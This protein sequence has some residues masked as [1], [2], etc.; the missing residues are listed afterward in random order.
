MDQDTKPGNLMEI[1]ALFCFIFFL[2]ECCISDSFS[3]EAFFL[4]PV[5]DEVPDSAMLTGAEAQFW[6]LLHSGGFEGQVFRWDELSGEAFSSKTQPLSHAV[7]T[8]RALPPWHSSLMRSHAHGLLLAL[9]FL[10]KFHHLPS[11]SV[12]CFF[13]G[14]TQN[15]RLCPCCVRSSC[16]LTPAAETLYSSPAHSMLQLISAMES[17]GG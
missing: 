3:A 8:L 10:P 6:G 13:A 5:D 1:W 16:A 15:P 7:F 17:T 9:P 11:T 4:N 12:P 14:E 2:A